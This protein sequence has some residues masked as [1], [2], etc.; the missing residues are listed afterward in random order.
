MK[1]LTIIGRGTV[2]CL[3]ATHFLRHTDW[4]I[5]WL[6]DP[7]ITPVSVGEGTTLIFPRSLAV[8]IDFNSEDVENIGGTTKLGA[9]KKN[10]GHGKEFKH[11]F[12]SGATGIHFNAVYFQQYLFEKLSKHHRIKTAESNVVDFENIDSDFVM[13][14]TGTPKNFDSDYY[15]HNHIP[16]NA[17][18]VLQCPWEY[19][20]F[21]YTVTFAKK[22]GWVFGIP[23]QKRCSI[24]YIFNKNFATEDQILEDVEDLLK[25]FQLT[26]SSKSLINFRNYSKKMNFNNRIAYNGNVSYFL[27]PLEATSTGFSDSVNRLA[28]DK[29][30]SNFSDEVVNNLF[31]QEISDIESMICMHYYAG[32][33][34][35]NEFWDYAKDISY[36]KLKKAFTNNGDF[37][38]IIYNALSSNNILDTYNRDVGQFSLRSYKINIEGLNLKEKLLKDFK[39][40]LRD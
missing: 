13:V 38:K 5:D 39:T 16:V 8:N 29:W 23:L 31:N 27:E 26:P 21:N 15:I 18:L 37:C 19:S 1:K 35:K 9:W 24:G 32:S 34:Y 20:K 28:Y 40:I 2:G 30:A 3:A 7:T 36:N 12:P 4:K 11:S 33:I 6:Y 14:C 22:Y 25:E 17:C 10:W